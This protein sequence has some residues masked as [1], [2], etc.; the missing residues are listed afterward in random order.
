MSR[1]Q[2]LPLERLYQILLYLSWE[3]LVSFCQTNRAHADIYRDSYFWRS[4]YHHDYGLIEFSNLMCEFPELSTGNWRRAYYCR[5]LTR[6]YREI[7]VKYYQ[8]LSSIRQLINEHAASQNWQA[9][10]QLLA[11]KIITYDELPYSIQEKL[12]VWSREMAF[13]EHWDAKFGD[14]DQAHLDPDH[15]YRDL[16]LGQARAEINAYID[17]M[18]QEHDAE[19]VKLDQ[20]KRG[21]L[22]GNLNLSLIDSSTQICGFATQVVGVSPYTTTTI[23]TEISGRAIVTPRIVQLVINIYDGLMT[24]WIPPHRR[25]EFLEFKYTYSTPANG[26]TLR[27]LLDKIRE[28]MKSY[29]YIAS[30]IRPDLDPRLDA[31]AIDGINYRDGKYFVLAHHF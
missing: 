5:T 14:L 31:I 30:L 29:L 17:V 2:A 26:F 28:S 4:K 7:Y 25:N 22:M 6:R 27:E 8:D 11:D 21:R 24:E 9:I 1:I 10:D 20:L 19:I 12:G 15:P 23:A 18:I 3:D 16:P 13:Q